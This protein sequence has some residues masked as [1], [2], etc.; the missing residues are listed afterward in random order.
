[1]QH[2]NT[3][4]QNAKNL[5]ASQCNTTQHNAT[6]KTTQHT[7]NSVQ[8]IQHSIVAQHNIT[9]EFDKDF[10]ISL[11]LPDLMHSESLHTDALITFILQNA[12]LLMGFAIILVIAVYE[13]DLRSIKF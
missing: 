5:T 1:M 7:V 6:Q 13:E 8:C 10:Y 4:Q 11:Q 9:Q 2:I 12:G 3:T